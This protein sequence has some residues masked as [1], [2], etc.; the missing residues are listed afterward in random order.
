[1]I[2]ITTTR[3]TIDK[4]QV[5]PDVAGSPIAVKDLVEADHQP[6]DDPLQWVEY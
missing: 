3:P 1:M 6:G 5:K 2:R 4:A